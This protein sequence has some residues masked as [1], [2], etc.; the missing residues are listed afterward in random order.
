MNLGSTAAGLPRASETFEDDAKSLEEFTP[1]CP[2]FD[3][4]IESFAAFVLLTAIQLS[5]SGLSAQPRR[6]I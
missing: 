5:N 3:K 4:L 1:G 6:S 2:R